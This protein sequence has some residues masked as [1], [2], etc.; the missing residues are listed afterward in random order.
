MF[1]WLI[2][3]WIFN[4]LISCSIILFYF[5]YLFAIIFIAQIALDT[6]SMART[7]LPKVPFPNSLI[8]TKSVIEILFCFGW[9]FVMFKLFRWYLEWFRFEGACLRVS[10]LSECFRRFLNLGEKS[11]GLLLSSEDSFSELVFEVNL[12]FLLSSHPKLFFFMS[13][14]SLI[15]SGSGPDWPKF[16]FEGF[17]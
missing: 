13:F 5:I 2:K 1:G 8:I 10:A 3:C 15:R 9:S 12:K 16:L 11:K 4:S 14:C 17:L 7:T 6:L